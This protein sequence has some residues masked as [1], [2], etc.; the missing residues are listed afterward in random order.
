PLRRHFH[1]VFTEHHRAVRV[2]DLARGQAEFDLRVGRLT[3]L[4]V[5]PLDPHFLPAPSSFGRGT[6]SA[7]LSVPTLPPRRRP[8]PPA[9]PIARCGLTPQYCRYRM[10][11]SGPDFLSRRAGRSPGLV[12]FQRHEEG[13]RQNHMAPAKRYL[14]PLR[15]RPARTRYLFRRNGERLGRLRHARQALVFESESNAKCGG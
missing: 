14:K 5:A 10:P 8:V 15:D 1:V 6:R 13:V 9:P 12:R 7:E 3:I 11:R 2:A 4:G